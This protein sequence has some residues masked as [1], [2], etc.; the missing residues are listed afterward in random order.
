MRFFTYAAG[1]E[2]VNPDHVFIDAGR[3]A[4][5]VYINNAFLNASAPPPDWKFKE[6]ALEAGFE[7]ASGALSIAQSRGA[8]SKVFKE[9]VAGI[10]AIGLDNWFGPGLRGLFSP[11]SIP[12]AFVGIDELSQLDL[13]HSTAC[14]TYDTMDV[15]VRAA[16]NMI[17]DGLSCRLVGPYRNHSLYLEY[18]RNLEFE[19]VSGYLAFDENG[20]RISDYAVFN[21]QFDPATSGKE[22]LLSLR[23]KLV[24]TWRHAPPEGEEA[25]V[26]IQGTTVQWRDGYP[27]PPPPD[28]APEVYEQPEEE[29]SGPSGTTLIAALSAVAGIVLVGAAALVLLHHR[30]R[31]SN[32]GQLE[33]GV[34][35]S[36][37]LDF[38]K[39]PV[40]SDTII[41]ELD[42]SFMLREV[43]ISVLNTW[44]VVPAGAILIR[45]KAPITR[46]TENGLLAVH[47]RAG[48]P[49]CVPHVEGRLL[50]PSKYRLGPGVAASSVAAT[51][52]HR[53]LMDISQEILQRVTDLPGHFHSGSPETSPAFDLP[54]VQVRIL[55]AP[56][57]LTGITHSRLTNGSQPP[58]LPGLLP[59]DLESG[60]SGIA[61]HRSRERPDDG[62]DMARLPFI[63]EQM[64]MWRPNLGQSVAALFS[65]ASTIRSNTEIEQ[66]K[67]VV[68]RLVKLRGSSRLQPIIG[69]TFIGSNSNNLA[70]AVV[71]EYLPGGN[72]HD[73]IHSNATPL[74]IDVRVQ[75]LTDI[76][77][78]LASLHSQEPPIVHP[79]ISPYNIAL[80]DD[81]RVVL[82]QY[83]YPTVLGAVNGGLL[84]YAAPEVLGGED[85]SPQSDVYSWAMIA[86]E[87][88]ERRELYEGLDARFVLQG[89]RDEWLRP[90]IGNKYPE[91]LQELLIECSAKNP[92]RRPTS[93]ELLLRLKEISQALKSIPADPSSAQ[94]LLNSIFPTE[95]AKQLEKGGRV[96]PEHHASV[97]IFFSDIVGFT[98]ISAMLDPAD[99]MAMLNRLYLALDKLTAHHGLF[100]VE[101]IGDAYMAV[102]NLHPKAED[103]AA[104]VARFAV[105]AIA[106]A[107]RV[108]VHLSRPDLGFV[109]MRVGFHT[110]PVVASVIGNLNPR[111]CLFG[112]TVNT[113]SRMESTSIE[114]RIHL[115]DT[116][117]R[118]LQ[119]QAP[120]IRC[121]LRTDLGEIK[122]KGKLKTFFLDPDSVRNGV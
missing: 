50:R 31:K 83:G 69:I 25:L 4:D 115:S 116:A 1:T 89:V 5:F 110:G 63:N 55:A 7:A 70:P 33:A 68:K 118:A 22:R 12:D 52:E 60:D 79:N 67:E 6:G 2:L 88:L 104:R 107:A 62:S 19:G 57:T 24:M 90:A 38:D 109:R 29:P 103:H 59:G 27:G 94:T 77:A 15:F 97:T 114:G 18:I 58:T 80:D 112:D 41:T 36:Q 14:L 26:S 46:A 98:N 92:L 40:Y 96:E 82:T 49:G 13:L 75:L 74:D 87:V 28:G 71:A 16:D 64:A 100:K 54:E 122:G 23:P 42:G 105:E 99:V 32:N 35:D 51:E 120:E 17:E 106:E 3:L 8:G 47:R 48:V 78:G 73:I 91:G 101:T 44:A 113:A 61:S 20:D 65:G 45:T 95:V 86:L 30:L 119:E 56:E 66:L 85:P 9:F 37:A 39:R 84:Q 53:S 111:Y 117:F 72:L 43:R 108:P 10:N 121:T 81:M 102:G 76:V 93:T 21:M 11:P 34:L